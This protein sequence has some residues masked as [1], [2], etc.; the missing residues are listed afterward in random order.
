MSTESLSH[1]RRTPSEGSAGT[2]SDGATPPADLRLEGRM[3]TP[4][5]VFTVLAFNGPLAAVAGYLAFIIYF[6]G[7]GAPLMLAIAG[8][9]NLIF[10]VGFTAMSRYMPNP[11]AF[12]SYIT[13]GLGRVLGLGGA[14]LA[15]FAYALVILGVYAF[16]GI[17]SDQL[18]SN[19]F[20]GPH[21]AWYWYALVAFV[22]ITFLSYRNIAASARTLLVALAVELVMVLIFNAAVLINGGPQGRSLVPFDP[23]VAFSGN[24]GSALLF[25][26][27]LF[28][29]FE[30][31]AVFRE[32]VKRPLKTV[33][34]ATYI[35]VLAIGVLYVLTSW[36]LITAYGVDKA[37]KVAQTSPSDM[38]IKAVGRYVG[39]VGVDIVS[40]LLI[41]ST[42]AALLST[43]NVLVRYLFSL[44]KDGVLPG[45]LGQV[46]RRHASPYKAAL[47]VAGTMLVGGII[48]VVSAAD[49]G[50]AYGSL[51]GVGG[52]AIIVLETITSVAVLVYFR[53][54]GRLTGVSTWQT[55]IAPVV[56]TLGL[57]LVVYLALTNFS[58]LIGGSETLAIIFQI[59][60]LAVVLTGVVLALVYRRTRPAAYRRIGRQDV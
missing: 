23:N 3:G 14:F 19:T 58:T 48:I 41:T 55:V 51:A 28:L 15:V 9:I 4:E 32:E 21:I 29:G 6:G 44:G 20:S 39:T 49:P 22:V 57:G 27:G 11:G 60:T 17:I 31:T 1:E 2:S 33:P 59:V 54:A 50:I 42:F 38:F 40:I 34:R 30:A 53:R 25:S 45:F 7:V 8:V 52:F 43:S 35:A 26:V 47:V 56:A 12:Y 24:V 13:A 10:A 5:L 46:H 18:V 36:L 37:A 16:F